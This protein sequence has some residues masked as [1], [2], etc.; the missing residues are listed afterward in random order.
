MNVIDQ[1]LTPDAKRAVM[2]AI[3]NGTL[4]PHDQLSSHEVEGLRSL[5][6]PHKWTYQI[7]INVEV[8]S[9]SEPDLTHLEYVAEQ[10]VSGIR[11]SDAFPSLDPDD[12]IGGWHLDDET[13]TIAECG[14][15]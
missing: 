14:A 11:E 6:A 8:V 5:C 2:A 9:R 10:L 12:T 15:A 4:D 13:V 3:A 1:L 7:W